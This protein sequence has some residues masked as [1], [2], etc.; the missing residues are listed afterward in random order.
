MLMG[1]D[2]IL[3]S[4]LATGAADGAV[5]STMNFMTFNLPLKTLWESGNKT[6]YDLAHDLQLKTVAV[7]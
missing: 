4:A 2:E 5:G 1:R 7:I 3:T 6:E